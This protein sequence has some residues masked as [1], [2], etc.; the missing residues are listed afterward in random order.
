MTLLSEAIQLY[1]FDFARRL[2]AH[3]PQASGP[4]AREA[5]PSE[6]IGLPLLPH[7]ICGCCG[8]EFT[9]LE[10]EALAVLGYQPCG[11]YRLEYRNCPDPC[12]ST[13]AV[14]VPNV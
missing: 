5:R 13:L 6:G 10:W 3:S 1:H 2:V 8:R 14:E 9:Q 11:D 12:G 7:K 4:A